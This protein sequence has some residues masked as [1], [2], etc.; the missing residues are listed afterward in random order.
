MEK[1]P[2][3]PTPTSIREQEG[4]RSGSTCPVE[5]HQEQV[6]TILAAVQPNTSSLLPQQH[7][8]YGARQLEELTWAPS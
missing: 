1:L 3:S 7:F 2:R 6:H 8:L 4:L 5:G